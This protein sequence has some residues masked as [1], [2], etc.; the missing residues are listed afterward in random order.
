MDFVVNFYEL[1]D[2]S[3]LMA[4]WRKEDNNFTNQSN[5][6]YEKINLREP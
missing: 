2:T 1:H 6:W 4:S 5:G 3:W